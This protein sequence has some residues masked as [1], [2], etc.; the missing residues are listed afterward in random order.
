MIDSF[1]SGAPTRHWPAAGA[2]PAPVN[3]EQLMRTLVRLVGRQIGRVIVE[4]EGERIYYLVE[5]LRLGFLKLRERPDAALGAGLVAEIETLAPA[6]AVSVLRGFA[7]YFSM[8]NIAEEVARL[9][10]RESQ[11]GDRWP[12]S[13]REI[14]EGIRAEGVDCDEAV[15][16]VAGLEFV[17]VLTA[18]PTEARRRAVQ[19]C[20]RRLFRLVLDLAAPSIAPERVNALTE[21]I[22]AELQVLWKTNAVRAQRMTVQDEVTN[23]L[24]LFRDSLFVALPK[25][26]RRL[27]DAVRAV[28]G[29]EAEGFSGPTI[30]RFGS[31]IGSDRDGNPNIDHAATK[32]AARRQCL[33][34]LRE[35]AR[36]VADLRDALTQSEPYVETTPAFAEALA[37][38]ESLAGAVFRDRPDQYI[39]EPYRRKLALVL[40]R[41]RLRIAE[42]ERRLRDGAADAEPEAYRLPAALLADLEAVRDNLIANRDGRVAGGA[43]QDL[44]VLVRTFGF[45]L[46]TLDVREDAARHRAAVDEIVRRIE[47]NTDYAG[48]G[49][50]ERIDLLERL[51]RRS[52][53]VA[54]PIRGLSAETTETLA[55]FAAIR[56]LQAELGTRIV[57]TYVVSMADRPSAIMEVIF[58][59]RLAGL[60]EPDDDAWRVTLRFVPLFETIDA[61]DRSSETMTSL[62]ERGFYRDILAASGGVQEVMLGYSDSCKDG[63]IL[64]SSWN[65]QRA[66]RRL[67]QTFDAYNVPFTFFHG[68][69]G[70]FARGG[71]PT[72]DAIVAQAHASECREFKFTEQGE[73]LSFKYSNAETAAYEL[74]VGLS[75]LIKVSFTDPAK[76]ESDA[77]PRWAAAMTRLAAR[78]EAAYRDLIEG[79]SYLPDYFY[80]T[81]PVNELGALNI[82]SRPS[83]RSKARRDLSSI[84]AIPWVFGWSQSRMTLPAWYGVGSAIRAFVEEEDNGLE[85]LRAMYADWLFFRTLLDNI[86]MTHAKGSLA[87]ARAYSTLAKDRRAAERLFA[88]MAAEFSLTE[89]MVKTVTQ[90][91]SILADNPTLAFSLERRAPYIDAV[92]AL[93]VHLL[94]RARADDAEDWRQPLLLSINAVAAGVRNIG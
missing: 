42:I 88:K 27:E 16:R 22:R 31:W 70:S 50:P 78:G 39:R 3:A 28:Y 47:A 13:F 68:R 8:V 85:Q 91:P 69:G 82:G 40:H 11:S 26:L 76:R 2:R 21:D 71:G 51:T 67:A 59:A 17:P 52:L 10:E 53:P 12:R 94:R 83:H 58:L 63:G 73:V 29:R 18:H 64:S 43:L 14:M 81:T 38:D 30:I 62:L 36:R 45:H 9:R 72:H 75:G 19:T 89:T 66:Q 57:E 60:I 56:D 90:A 61:L 6:D 80:E 34:T 74:T 41:L 1:D 32:T 5:R 44:I 4:Q 54:L 33:E 92:N 20:H 23:G 87:V 55:T 86:Q 7:A 46:A 84:R 37:R 25:T 79:E 15:H 65:L 93:Q 48:L 35:Y 49:E 77:E 24:L